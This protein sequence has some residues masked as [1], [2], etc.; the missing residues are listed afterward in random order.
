MGHMETGSRGESVRI[1]EMARKMIFSLSYL[2]I[3]SLWW[4]QIKGDMQ[5]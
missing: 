5:R 2:G 3:I 1:S 4:M